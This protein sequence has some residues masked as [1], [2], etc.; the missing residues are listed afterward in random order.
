MLTYLLGLSG[1]KNRKGVTLFLGL[2]ASEGVPKWLSI[3]N[4]DN[5]QSGGNKKRVKEDQKFQLF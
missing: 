1:K 4:K 3:Q 5:W 2:A